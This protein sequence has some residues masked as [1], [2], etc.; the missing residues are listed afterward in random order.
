MQNYHVRKIYYKDNLDEIFHIN[1]LD[2]L[3]LI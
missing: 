3:I 2:N 1:D